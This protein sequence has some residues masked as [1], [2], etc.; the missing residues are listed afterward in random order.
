MFDLIGLKIFFASCYNYL[1]MTYHS[2]ALGIKRNFLHFI[3]LFFFLVR[4]LFI[5]TI[6]DFQ[7]QRVPRM[8]VIWC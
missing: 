4:F 3:Y 6:S 5:I 8:H 7:A 1:G 2:N